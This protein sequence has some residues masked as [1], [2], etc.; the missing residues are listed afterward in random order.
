M[1]LSSW[2]DGERFPNRRA[3]WEMCQGTQW[4]TVEP[5]SGNELDRGRNPFVNRKRM[6]T[7]VLRRA[8]HLVPDE[9]DIRRADTAPTATCSETL[10]H[11]SMVLMMQVDL[12][13]STPTGVV[14]ETS[15]CTGFQGS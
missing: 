3:W 14:L 15:S 8:M 6:V 11:Q 10:D 7:H 12:R 2:F 13:L 5:M 1:A 4:H 9:D